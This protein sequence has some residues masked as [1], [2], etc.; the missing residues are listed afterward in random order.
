MNQVSTYI[1]NKI[2]E[3]NEQFYAGT[4][5]VSEKIRIPSINTK[6]KNQNQ[7]C[8]FDWKHMKNQQ[9]YAKMIKQKKEISIWRDKK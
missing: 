1:K 8:N 3:L 9:K 6:K 7:D 2:T 5:L 4:K